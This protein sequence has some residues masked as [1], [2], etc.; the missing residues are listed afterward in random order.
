MGTDAHL[1][2]VR[3]NDDGPA[4]GYSAF[5]PGIAGARTLVLIHGNTRHTGKMFRA[6]LPQAAELGLAII[7]PTFPREGFRGYQ[8]LAG[9]AGPMAAR[10]ALDDTLLDAQEVLGIATDRM[11]LC[12]FSGGAQFAQRYALF[13][14][15]RIH[16]L[17]VASAGYYTHLD[18]ELRYPYG[19]GPSALSGGLAPDVDEFLRLPVHV[20]VGEQ[21]VDRDEGLRVGVRLDRSQGR[22]R[23]ARALHWVDHL[24]AAAADR[25]MRSRVSFDVLPG[26]AHSFSSAVHRGD[27]VARVLAFA[28]PAGASVNRIPLGGPL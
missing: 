24:E 16:R 8:R 13:S 18:P 11:T 12:G 3:G 2:T 10:Q 28:H 19:V 26:T 17:V 22:N 15:G 7:V 1:L 9:S 25:G 5:V 6:F 14:P 27:L 23:L 20:L 4:L 21:D